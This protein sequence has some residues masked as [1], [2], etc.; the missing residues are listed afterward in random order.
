M[1]ETKYAR[2]KERERERVRERERENGGNLERNNR[3]RLIYQGIE[4]SAYY[5]FKNKER[6]STKMQG[7]LNFAAVVTLKVINGINQI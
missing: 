5:F 3:K 4:R 1:K 2:E 7:S 6:L